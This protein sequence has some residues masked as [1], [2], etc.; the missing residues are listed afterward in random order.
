MFQL[1]LASASMISSNKKMG[2]TPVRLE[3]PERDARRYELLSAYLLLTGLMRRVVVKMSP[4][5]SDAQRYRLLRDHVLA[6]GI[7]RHL[8][9]PGSESVPF[10]VGKELYGETVEEAVD[11]LE[12][13]NL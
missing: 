4:T 6:T 9:L 7:I 1:A 13:W 8:K 10:V 5:D 2:T 11:T 12:R 3:E